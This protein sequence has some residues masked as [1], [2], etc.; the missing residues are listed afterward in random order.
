MAVHCRGKPIASQWVPFSRI[1]T[2]RNQNQ[3]RVELVGNGQYDGLEGEKV[4]SV[5]HLSPVEWNVHIEAL[6][7]TI[8]YHV[9]V[10]ILVRWEEGGIVI[11]G[12]V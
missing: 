3:L 8:S 11:P 10:G 4:L 2:R 12:T 1:K 7:R 9:I 5:T 6:A